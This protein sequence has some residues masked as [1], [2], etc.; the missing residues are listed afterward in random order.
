MLVKYVALLYMI[1][2]LSVTLSLSLLLV[3]LRQ[4]NE[5]VYGAEPVSSRWWGHKGVVVEELERIGS[6]DAAEPLHS[7]CC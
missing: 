2:S 5:F 1:L 4:T 6:V 3:T 7:S